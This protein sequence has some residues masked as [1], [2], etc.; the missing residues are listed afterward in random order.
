ME[1]FRHG[2][3]TKDAGTSYPN[4]PHNNISFQPYGLGELT[5]GGRL[6]SFHLGEQLRGRYG[7]YLNLR[8]TVSEINSVTT[9]Y[10]RAQDTL[11]LVLDGLFNSKGS[12]MKNAY[13]F[14]IL[15]VENSSVLTFPYYFCPR[16]RQIYREYQ[17]FGEG[18]KIKSK[19]TS[20][21][22]YIAY[23]TGNNIECLSDLNLLYDCLST[24]EEWKLHLPKWTSL[25][26]RDY[27]ESAA[28]DFHSMSVALPELNKRY[29]GVLLRQI[30][31]QMDLKINHSMNHKLHLYSAH[32]MNVVGL[33]G[34]MGLYHPHIVPYTAC[35]L[36]ELHEVNNTYCVK[37]LYQQTAA[38]G[39][40][41]MVLPGCEALCPI[42]SFRTI[43]AQN[44]P[45]DYDNC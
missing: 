5:L 25:V 9:N 12:E 39:F 15:Q 45:K 44:L 19:Y 23:H 37:V 35:V 17:D 28:K 16:Y 21:F 36:M 13:D 26:Y 7:D 22:P 38:L 24:E 3:R 43:I 40:Q 30:L 32:D 4:D 31:D 41:E 20:N 1:V 10:N 29:G 14:A 27:L 18:R 33:L 2:D 8:Y 42:K 6:R 34:A 11:R